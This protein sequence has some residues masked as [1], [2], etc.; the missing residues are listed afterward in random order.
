[1]SKPKAKISPKKKQAS[2]GVPL[3]VLLA[4]MIG[5]LL[6][7]VGGEV[8]FYSR[9]HPVHWTGILIGSAL[10]A[11]IAYIFFRQRGDII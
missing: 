2:E 7:Y 9:P 3:V 10:G 8:V 5:A 4:S 11:L 1:M 6:G